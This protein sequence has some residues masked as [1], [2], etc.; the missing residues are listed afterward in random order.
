[1]RFVKTEE[2]VDPLRKEPRFQAIERDLNDPE[3]RKLEQRVRS[4]C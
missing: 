2:L 1:L 4:A 3:R